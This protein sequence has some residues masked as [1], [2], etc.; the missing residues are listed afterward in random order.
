[1]IPKPRLHPRTLL[2]SSKSSKQP[3]W[4]SQGRPSWHPGHNIFPVDPSSLPRVLD[5]SWQ[6]PPPLGPQLVSSCITSQSFLFM[7]DLL[8]NTL[9]ALTLLKWW[10]WIPLR[11]N[12]YS[13]YM[14]SIMEKLVAC[15]PLDNT[16]NKLLYTALLLIKVK[17]NNQGQLRSSGDV[18]VVL[19]ISSWQWVAAPHPWEWVRGQDWWR[20]ELRGTLGLDKDRIFV[21]S[22]KGG[23]GVLEGCG[24]G[25]PNQSE[26]IMKHL[27][28]FKIMSFAWKCQKLIHH[29]SHEV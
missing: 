19:L 22:Q 26:F 7:P 28:W 25:D 4:I 16:W 17:N 9:N 11:H 10:N 18:L 15:L 2:P 5:L 27:N 1:M 20:T 3:H 29:V 12:H 8:K 6:N 23:L 14:I 24:Y 13:R 21:L